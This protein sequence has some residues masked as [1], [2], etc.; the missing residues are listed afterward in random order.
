MVTNSPKK[1]KNTIQ[2]YELIEKVNV[3]LFKTVIYEKFLTLKV[4]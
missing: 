4:E 1:L 2:T 3:F